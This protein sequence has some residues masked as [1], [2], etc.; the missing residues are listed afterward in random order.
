MSQEEKI[1]IIIQMLEKSLR[2]NEEAPDFASSIWLVAE[3]TAYTRCLAVIAVKDGEDLSAFAQGLSN[4]V[5]SMGTDS[6][7]EYITGEPEPA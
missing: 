2:D 7:Y 5:L 3:C 4:R 1:K 6:L